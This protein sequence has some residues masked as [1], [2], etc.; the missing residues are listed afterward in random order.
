MGKRI[1]FVCK[2][3]S[4]TIWEAQTVWEN[5][6]PSTNKLPPL[7]KMTNLTSLELW[8]NS[9]HVTSSTASRFCER[10][11]NAIGRMSRLQALDITI[12]TS[13]LSPNILVCALLDPAHQRCV[14]TMRHLRRLTFSAEAAESSNPVDDITEMLSVIVP[15]CTELRHLHLPNLFKQMSSPIL[16]ETF[17]R[18]FA[19]VLNLHHLEYF[20]LPCLRIEHNWSVLRQLPRL[21][22]LCARW[23]PRHFTSG[24]IDNV[25]RRNLAFVELL[26]DEHVPMI[27]VARPDLDSLV[28]NALRLLDAYQANNVQIAPSGISMILACCLDFGPTRKSLDIVYH[29]L[30]VPHLAENSKCFHSSSRWFD[31]CLAICDGP[32]ADPDALQTQLTR[33]LDTLLPKGAPFSSLNRRSQ[34]VLLAAVK[35]ILC[36]H[37]SDAEATDVGA[38]ILELILLQRYPRIFYECASAFPTLI[39]QN[40][41]F[42]KEIF[43]SASAEE[44]TKFVVSCDG[45]HTALEVIVDNGLLSDIDSDDILKEIVLLCI[46]ELDSDELV[47][48]Y[49]RTPQKSPFCI[50]LQGFD[51]DYVNLL[52]ELGY[53]VRPE[54]RKLD[55]FLPELF[56]KFPNLQTF[57]TFLAFFPDERLCLSKF[58]ANDFGVEV[59]P[60]ADRWAIFARALELGAWPGP[61]LLQ[62]IAIADKSDVLNLH[63]DYLKKR[64]MIQSEQPL[65][66]QYLQ[67]TMRHKAIKCIQCLATCGLDLNAVSFHVALSGLQFEKSDVFVRFIVDL[68]LA[69]FDLNRPCHPPLHP[70]G[71]EIV[72][73]EDLENDVALVKLLRLNPF[74]ESDLIA[75]LAEKGVT[76]PLHDQ[77]ES[78]TQSCN[79]C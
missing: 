12:S 73:E 39:A 64:Q 26:Y 46:K 47:S 58:R 6:D 36:H 5:D 34:S 3:W 1:H 20:G 28:P 49:K 51:F 77:V 19:L 54:M 23:N 25:L 66:H 75:A 43:S 29:P 9:E 4:H 79:I 53:K 40:L 32:A 2:E 30:I 45:I 18:F 50:A 15:T 71:D 55:L 33:I 69:G 74:A 60:G 14:E 38:K 56:A 48:R 57:D 7:W 35:F 52:L 17:D 24:H 67:T 65:L 59:N 44:K 16:Q 22:Q 72:F 11:S 21:K 10:I 70:G 42:A 61:G 31:L 13:E 62:R 63:L 37:E 8:I 68:A 41:E 76:L 27:A 78:D